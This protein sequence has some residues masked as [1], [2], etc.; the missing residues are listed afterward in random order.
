MKHSKTQLDAYVEKFK[1][2]I[3]K[4]PQGIFNISVKPAPD[5]EKTGDCE[6]VISDGDNHDYKRE[7]GEWSEIPHIN[8]EK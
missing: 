8:D 2:E 4:N 1:E 6:L 5:Y 7:S 3:K